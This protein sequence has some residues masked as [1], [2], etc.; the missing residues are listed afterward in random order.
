MVYE[1]GRTY[2]LDQIKAR[3]ET[4]KNN[5]LLYTPSVVVGTP[6][7]W[8]VMGPIRWTGAKRT[9]SR[10]RLIVFARSSDAELHDHW[11]INIGRSMWAVHFRRERQAKA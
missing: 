5:R 9:Q 11:P 2:P 7:G 1:G 6:F 3:I 10:D 8:I 4:E